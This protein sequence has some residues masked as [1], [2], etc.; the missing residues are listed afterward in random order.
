MK[1]AFFIRTY[2][3]DYEW[4]KYCLRSLKKHAPG[5][6]V[7]V[8]WPAGEPQP[9]V[10]DAPPSC[11][12]FPVAPR[13]RDDYIGQQITKMTADK[14]VNY[15]WDGAPAEYVVHIDSDTVL[16]DSPE[17]L[18]IGGKPQMLRTPYDQLPMEVQMWKACTEKHLGWGVSHEYMRRLPLVYPIGLYA[19]LRRYLEIRHRT[20]FEDWGR[21]V[22]AGKLSEFN[23]LGA[24]AFEHM[25]DAFHWIDTDCDTLPPLVAKQHWSWGGIDK[26]RTELETLFPSQ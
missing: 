21:G 25:H 13:H 16:T 5:A 23:L 11:L 19:E 20:S 6:R 24:Y 14:W 7:V 4:L 2:P 9:G 1:Y 10:L 22:E 12:F 8:T 3:R 15:L 26:Y 17:H 18:F